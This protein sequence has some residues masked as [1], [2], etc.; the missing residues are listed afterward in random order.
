MRPRTSF[1]VGT[2]IALAHP[3]PLQAAPQTNV[4]RFLDGMAAS[5]KQ[6]Q[7]ERTARFA[8]LE[9]KL[10]APQIIHLACDFVEKARQRQFQIHIS[11][12]S[13][14]DED[15]GT[16]LIWTASASFEG[17]PPPGLGTK[18]DV[19]Y[20]GPPDDIGIY[21]QSSEL[22]LDRVSWGWAAQYKAGLIKCTLRAGAEF[23][24]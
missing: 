1:W 3:S 15:M 24:F 16:S 13:E 11:R 19:S 20:G 10:K 22:R 2:L 12:I 6:A 4:D 14:P 18:E 7:E 8:E 23:V 17:E 5:S 9:N 21:F